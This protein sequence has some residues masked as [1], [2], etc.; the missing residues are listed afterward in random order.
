M[1][2]RIRNHFHSRFMGH[3]LNSTQDQEHIEITSMS[4]SIRDKL[5]FKGKTKSGMN[6]NSEANQS[7]VGVN[8][9]G[10]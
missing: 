2:F 4:K 7:R 3:A 6:S 10:A 5:K 1:G 8:R 9:F